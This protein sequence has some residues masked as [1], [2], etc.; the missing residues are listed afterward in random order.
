MGK[1]KIIS[2][3]ELKQVGEKIFSQNG[4]F[5]TKISDIVTEAGVSQGTFYLNYDSKKALFID[6]LKDFRE[7]LIFLL[8]KQDLKEMDSEK[9][10]V[11]SQKRLF[12]YLMEN[13]TKTSLIYREGYAEKDFAIILEDIH[14]ILTETRS[15]MLKDIFGEKLSD[16]ERESY[17]YMIG[18]L[19]RSLFMFY[20]RKNPTKDEYSK[21]IEKV[22]TR[23]L[24]CL[25]ADI[26]P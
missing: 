9:A 16:E 22:L 1:K 6:L 2:K 10:L 18:G 25:K 15:R 21:K 11:E 12:S 4:Y 19:I 3:E 7:G 5:L 14:R 8:N 26:N 23:F 24:T 17:S 13:K 20:E